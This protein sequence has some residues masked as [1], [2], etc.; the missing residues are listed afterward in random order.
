MRTPRCSL[1]T[2]CAAGPA[3]VA[4]LLIGVVSAPA[5]AGAL[6][7]GT[8]DAHASLIVDG[9]AG[10]P[11]QDSTPSPTSPTSS[12]PAASPTDP[13]HVAPDEDPA[14]TVPPSTEPENHSW[15]WAGIAALLL[16]TMLTLWLHDRS[17]RKDPQ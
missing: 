2:R 3:A 15:A 4:L 1:R 8:S 11:A 17:R 16:G 14:H 7:P 10:S 12:A 13:A 6:A 9:A 5:N